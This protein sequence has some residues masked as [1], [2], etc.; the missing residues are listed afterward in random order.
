MTL[1][2]LR[3]LSIMTSI[4]CF[5]F[6][7]AFGQKNFVAIH[8][9]DTD[10][11]II[12]KA[13]KVVPSA[14]QLQW[15]QLELTAFIHFGMNTFTGREWGTGNEH[16]NLF[17]PAQLDTDQWVTTL[18]AAGFKQIVFTAKHH[19]GFCM[20][21][22]ATTEHSV[23]SSIWKNGKGDVVKELAESCK[24]YGLGF[25]IYLSPWDMNAGSYGSPAYNDLFADQLKEL[26]T[27]YGTIKEVW[28]DGANGE[29][30][31]GQKQVYDFQRWYAI[32]RKLQ[33]EAVIAVMGPDVRWVG[34]ETGKGREEE[35]SVVPGTELNLNKTEENSQ[36][37]ILFSPSKDLTDQVLGNRDKILKAKTLVWYP[38]ETD[39][40]IM[41]GWFYNDRH[42]VKSPKKMMDIYF[43]SVGMN[44]VLLLN[45]PPDRRGLIPTEILNTLETWTKQRH[46]IFR[47]NLLRDSKIT[48]KDLKNPHFLVDGLSATAAKAR[49]KRSHYTIEFGIEDPASFNVLL[50]QEDISR[51]QRIEAFEAEFFDGK[52]WNTFAEGTTVGHK[53]LIRTRLVKA[54]RIRL[55]IKQSRLNPHLSEVGLYYEKP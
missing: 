19:D 17:D 49:K 16:P 36:K 45:I 11:D 33:P 20:W 54:S 32:I 43:T 42:K 48:T 46:A 21:P 51:G 35:W 29:G 13:A 38:A 8:P 31:N 22:T 18:K 7:A 27:N 30:A 14:R 4:F 50:L 26:L 24:K 25:G 12:R 15:Q 34:T 52:N 3:L 1:L 10:D 23:K 53:R 5:Y 6:N 37:E 2:Q 28:F 41:D 40:S 55:R 9:H 39:V 44:S 47:T